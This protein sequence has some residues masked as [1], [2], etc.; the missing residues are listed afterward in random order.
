MAAE[1][2][3]FRCIGVGIDSPLLNLEKRSGTIPPDGETAAGFSLDSFTG[4]VSNLSDSGNGGTGRAT[5]LAAVSVSAGC[6]GTIIRKQR[7][8]PN[9]QELKK[10]DEARTILTPVSS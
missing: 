6:D 9:S 2:G 3:A 10:R 7:D 4:L 5:D 8:T 1:Q